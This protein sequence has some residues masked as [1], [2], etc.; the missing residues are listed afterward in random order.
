MSKTPAFVNICTKTMYI[1]YVCMWLNYN[2][3]VCFRK[4]RFKF[5]S[6]RIASYRERVR[7]II[8]YVFMLTYNSYMVGEI[9]II[10]W[11]IAT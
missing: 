2:K 4:A 3:F 7:K 9:Q 5:A 1:T 8:I 11:S 6:S 10:N